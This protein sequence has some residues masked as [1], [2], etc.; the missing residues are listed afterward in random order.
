M[1][2]AYSVLVGKPERGDRLEDLSLDGKIILERILEKY[3][4]NLWNGCIWLR[5]GTS[6]GL[7]NTVMNFRVP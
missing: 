7:V 6:G 3:G 5:T 4:V 2:N 1:R